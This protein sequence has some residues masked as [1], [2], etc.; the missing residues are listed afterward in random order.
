LT[1]ITYHN[2]TGAAITVTWSLNA[3]VYYSFSVQAGA[4]QT[5]SHSHPIAGNH[6]TN[7]ASNYLH[8]GSASGLI[9]TA[10]GI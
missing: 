10:V 2:P 5:F 9:V 8:V 1:E 7:G 3:V 4:S 6:F